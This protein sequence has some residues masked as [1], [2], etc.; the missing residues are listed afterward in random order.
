MGE[1]GSRSDVPQ[2]HQSPPTPTH[3]DR[4]LVGIALR[5]IP[6]LALVT[7]LVAWGRSLAEALGTEAGRYD[8]STYYAAA[9]ALRA[10][11]HANVYD[12]SVLARAGATAHVLVQPPLAYTYPPLFALLFSPFTALSFRTLSRVWLLGNAALVLVIVCLLAV[13][14]RAAL[15]IPQIATA[16]FWRRT[17]LDAPARW[18]ADPLALLTL[19]VAALLCLSSAPVAQTL[20]TGQVDVLVL[21][22]LTLVPWLTRR[23]HERWVGVAIACAAMLKFTPVLL[24]A[25]LLLRRRWQAAA[26]ALVTLAVLAALSALVVGPGLVLASLGQALRVGGG[27]ATLAHNEALFAPL[28]TAL[29]QGTH[30]AVGALHVVTSMLTVG[31][32]AAIGV[33]LWR[34]PAMGTAAPPL[35]HA[36]QRTELAAYG[37]ALCALLLLAPTAWV[38]HYVWVLPA[39]V[40]AL[41]FVGARQSMAMRRGRRGRNIVQHDAAPLVLVTLACMAVGVSLPYAWDSAPH[42]A[43]T[44][45]AGLPLWP[46]ALELRPLGT[47]ALL[48]VLV[49]TTRR[50]QATA[51]EPAASATAPVPPQTAP[52]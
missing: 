18:L 2:V 24:I 32:A 35:V 30:S 5:G 12:P 1:T 14:L 39:A 6:L 52:A 3:R 44:H 45:I 50:S 36:P 33:V 43:V 15:G 16:L 7:S 38:H 42:P 9:A 26:G 27:D 10:D 20:V 8:F 40:L 37:M 46:L 22:P 23:G 29:T 19:A 51:S 41:G 28:V 49:W 4:S 34:L 48:V 31:L 11:W 21:L 13:E 25:Y 17:P 47:L